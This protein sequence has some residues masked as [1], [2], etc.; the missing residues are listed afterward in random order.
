MKK[1][2]F[3]LGALCGAL[4]VLLLG[5][6]LRTKTQTQFLQTSKTEMK[7]NVFKELIKE[8]Y[9]YEDEVDEAVLENS[10]IKGYIDGLGDP[11]SVYYDEQETKE[12]LESTKGEFTG[13]GVVMQQDSATKVITFVTVYKDSPAEKGGLKNGDVLYKVDGENV[14]SQELDQI[15]AKVR[16]EKGT[17]VEITVL[18]GEELEEVTTTLKRDKIEVQTVESGMMKEHIGFLRISQFDTVTYSQFKEAL[19]DLHKQGAKGLIFDVRNNP[20]GNLDTVCEILDLILPEGTIVYT[21][22]KNG[23]KETFTSDE[24]NQLDIPM[25]VLING[26]SASA[27][28][29]FAGAIKDYK[30]G[31]LVGETTYGKGV[32]QQIFP[33]TDGTSIKLT[34]SE[35]FTPKGQSIHKKGVEPDVEVEYTEMDNQ[36]DKAFEIVKDK[37]GK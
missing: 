8:N 12:L 2:W 17:A 35:Y 26:A 10:M 5:I 9:L 13:I 28:E 30:V 27:S 7:I 3:I 23:Q 25:V 6:V 31:T 14:S 18:R 32:V 29:I 33:L 34:I 4:T 37:V 36:L 22:D 24:K 11:Y 15:V 20:G 1:R 21:E 16:G 19:E